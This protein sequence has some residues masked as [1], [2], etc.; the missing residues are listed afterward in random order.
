M[1]HPDL[2]ILAAGA[3]SHGNTSKEGAHALLIGAPLDSAVSRR[4]AMLGNAAQHH[5]IGVSIVVKNGTV[6][7][8][9]SGW[10]EDKDQ[11]IE[12]SRRGC[13][14]DVSIASMPHAGKGTRFSRI[15][16]A[17]GQARIWSKT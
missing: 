11:R 9:L 5:L 14:F 13:W 16:A 12:P 6:E 1:A 4:N 17:V 3:G 15:S 10:L 2:V 8:G 7:E